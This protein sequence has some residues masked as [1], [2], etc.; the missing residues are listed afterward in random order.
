MI[1]SEQIGFEWRLLPI[2]WVTLMLDPRPLFM[3]GRGAI[4]VYPWIVP[5]LAGMAVYLTMPDRRCS[6]ISHAIVI[7]AAAMYLTA[8]FFY[9]Q[10]EA[11][12]IWRYM[13]YHY[14]KWL[15]PVFGFYA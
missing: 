14:F 13:V 11:Y 8:Y 6:R 12:D 3:E 5:G 15:F 2:R 1:G 4:E 9:Q 10:K 7:G